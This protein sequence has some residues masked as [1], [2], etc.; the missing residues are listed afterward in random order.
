MKN[1]KVISR[2]S[3]YKSI[4]LLVIIVLLFTGCDILMPED[5]L[6]LAEKYMEKDN[7]DKAIRVYENLIDED[8]ENYEAWFGLTETYMED[9]EYDDAG[10]TLE[11]MAEVIIDNYDAEE[12][13]FIDVIDDYNKLAK[14]LAA[15]NV[16]IKLLGD[17]YK[18]EVGDTEIQA[19]VEDLVGLVNDVLG[20]TVSQAEIEPAINAETVEEFIAEL[21]LTELMAKSQEII[22]LTDEIEASFDELDVDLEDED[23]STLHEPLM[24]TLSEY[25]K[26]ASTI[27]DVSKVSEDL[28]VET[29]SLSI[30]ATDFGTEVMANMNN[31]SPEFQTAI[32]DNQAEYLGEFEYLNSEEFQ[33]MMDSGIVDKPILDAAIIRI[34]AVRVKLDE[35]QTITDADVIIKD[36]LTS[37]V[38]NMISMYN[39]LIDGADTLAITADYEGLDTFV[40][41]YIDA[42]A[43]SIDDWVSGIE[44]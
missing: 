30:I 23:V 7:I 20:L 21:G 4:G 29:Y 17:T 33:G 44:E 27:I 2:L 8:D 12:E 43:S 13:D 1:I 26:M 39:V 25:K 36:I 11:D 14:K 37:L 40:Q 19:Q 22:D 5:S 16:V 38:D 3:L 34:E 28:L 6:E 42:N 32:F 24:D 15:E 10:D 9:D 41:E 18:K 31:L 35:L